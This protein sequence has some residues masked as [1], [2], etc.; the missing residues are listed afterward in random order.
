MPNSAYA[1]YQKILAITG[2]S[3]HEMLR[4]GGHLLWSTIMELQ[5]LTVEGLTGDVEDWTENKWIQN[6]RK[7]SSLRTVGE[8]ID[9]GRRRKDFWP[10]VH[11]MTCNH[12]YPVM[13]R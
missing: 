3:C 12:L 4:M 8:I 1:K 10:V 5:H 9:I 6:I 7:C 11:S 2:S 13:G